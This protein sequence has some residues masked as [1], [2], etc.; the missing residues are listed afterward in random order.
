MGM[1]FFNLK[2]LSDEKA[3]IHHFVY[4]IAGKSI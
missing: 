3:R 1:I 2:K 4:H